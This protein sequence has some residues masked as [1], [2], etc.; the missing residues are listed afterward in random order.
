M[1]NTYHKRSYK[2][3]FVIQ[4]KETGEI[5]YSAIWSSPPW[6]ASQMDPGTM[7]GVFLTA[8]ADSF[9]NARLALIK[10]IA[11]WDYYRPTFR[12][13]LEKARF[14]EEFEEARENL[15]S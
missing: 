15:K 14:K 5:D 11:S 7:A 13:A 1:D 2:A 8:T 12:P 4:F 10:S 9:H 6:E 3:Y